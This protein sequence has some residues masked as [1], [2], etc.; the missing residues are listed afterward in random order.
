MAKGQLVL[1]EAEVEIVAEAVGAN[2]D[3]RAAATTPEYQQRVWR[4]L[5]KLDAHSSR[6]I[7]GEVI[8]Y[9]CPVWIRKILHRTFNPPQVT[10]KKKPAAKAAPAKPAKPTPAQVA[11]G[12]RDLHTGRTP[13]PAQVAP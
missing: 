11:A 8:G 1:N 12:K 6:G 5:V 2:I 7:L 9:D 4:L 13:S 3:H 10:A